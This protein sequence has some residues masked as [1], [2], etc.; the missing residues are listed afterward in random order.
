MMSPAQRDA[1][2]RETRIATLVTLQA[3]GAPTAVPV[4]FE[5][6]GKTIQVFTSRRSAKIARI[7]SDARV[8]LA[9]AEPVGVPEAW[10]TVEGTASIEDEG[11]MELARRLAARYY[12]PDRA[13]AALASWE[14]QAD[15]WVVIRITP[16]R[17]ASTGPA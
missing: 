12:T 4:W 8:C 7:R 14:R 16:T 1:F 3:G 13:A 11:G 10:V 9:V 15:E 6:D 17:I 2:L 5:W